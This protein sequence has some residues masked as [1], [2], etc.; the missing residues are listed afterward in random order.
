MRYSVQ[1]GRGFG[2]RK[3]GLV[4]LNAG[5]LYQIN[6]DDV[7]SSRKIGEI[8]DIVTSNLAYNPADGYLYIVYLDA[9]HIMVRR[10]RP[11]LSGMTTERTVTWSGTGFGTS[12]RSSL[13]HRGALWAIRSIKR[14]SGGA[15]REDLW[16]HRIRVAGTSY[17]NYHRK[18]RDNINSQSAAFSYNDRIQYRATRTSST[19][20]LSYITLNADD[21]YVSTQEN[22]Q[23]N[24][25]N[26]LM[27]AAVHRGRI[28]S[29]HKNANLLRSGDGVGSW[30]A[31]LGT[32][33]GA[34]P[35]T[36]GN[37]RVGMA[38]TD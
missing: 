15:V 37:V 38:S 31:L 30:G 25:L 12:I 8:N 19:P 13:F 27:A 9:T 33:L 24:S 11:D 22:F 3:P 14:S 26:N 20:E 23:E 6:T 2:W 36:V 16:L 4:A 17:S 34:P 1:T 18:F 28:Y 7:S 21:E 32:N 35:F 5:S 29:L 10:F